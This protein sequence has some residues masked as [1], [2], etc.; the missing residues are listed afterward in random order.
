MSSLCYERSYFKC[1]FIKITRVLY[2]CIPVFRHPLRNSHVCYL[3]WYYLSFQWLQYLYYMLTDWVSERHN[4]ILLGAVDFVYDL[5]CH[6]LLFV[7]NIV[8]QSLRHRFHLNILPC[9]PYCFSLHLQIKHKHLLN[10]LALFL[11]IRF[12]VHSKIIQY[13][14]RKKQTVA[15][16]NTNVCFRDFNFKPSSFIFLFRLSNLL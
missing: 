8:S 12:S 9:H 1:I 6:W 5:H 16:V 11:T 3:L 15:I 10:F 2:Q 14:S 7:N 4:V 13:Y